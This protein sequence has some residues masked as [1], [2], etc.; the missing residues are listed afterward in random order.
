MTTPETDRLLQTCAQLDPAYF[1]YLVD[2]QCTPEQMARVAAAA[3]Y[4]RSE[5]DDIR[6]ELLDFAER[7]GIT[8]E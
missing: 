8:I 5:L 2:N 1:E 6:R 4:I 7:N 3:Q